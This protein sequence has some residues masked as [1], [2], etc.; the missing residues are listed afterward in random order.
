MHKP[1][2]VICEL[3]P[4]ELAGEKPGQL[5]F[6]APWE[7]S[8]QSSQEFDEDIMLVYMDSVFW[9]P[10]FED[11]YKFHLAFDLLAPL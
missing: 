4:L 10:F 2:N 8:V 11:Y 7:S 5:Y 3:H 9:K 6:S 1:M